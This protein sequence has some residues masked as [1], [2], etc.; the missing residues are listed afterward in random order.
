MITQSFHEDKDSLFSPGAFLGERKTLCDTAIATF[1]HKIFH[2]VLEQYPHQEV[3]HTGSANGHRPV[4]LLDLPDRQV[5]FYLSSIGSCLAGNDIIEI[6]WQTGFTRLILFGSAGALDSQATA[7]KYVL[8]TYA[9]RDEG[10]S[11]HYA[12]PADFIRIPHSETLAAIFDRL[13]LPY[14]MGKTWTTDA[15]Y[16]ET[17][18]AVAQRKQDG[19]LTV[20]M[21]LAGVQ[22]VCD[23]YGIELYD[24]LVTGDVLD[25]AVYVPDG[26]VEANHAIDKFFVA[27][28][29][30]EQ[31]SGP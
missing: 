12:P 18:S 13:H 22:A 28:K 19:C 2:A 6:Q 16:R 23:F 24:F 26:L 25:G 31:L 14:V 8:P 20:E 17:R 5:I 11:Y 29:I 4:Y 1:S 15:P 3:A 21:E 30:I 27:L 7:G 9:Y 10:M